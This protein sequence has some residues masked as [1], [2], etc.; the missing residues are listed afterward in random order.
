MVGLNLKQ[1]GGGYIM[2]ESRNNDLIVELVT[3]DT[4]NQ[5]SCGPNCRPACCSPVMES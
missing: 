5:D 1:K 4:D 3:L 2:E